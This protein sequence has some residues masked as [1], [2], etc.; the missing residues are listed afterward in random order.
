MN[1]TPLH[2]AMGLN[3]EDLVTLLLANDADTTVKDVVCRINMIRNVCSNLLTVL[4]WLKL[5]SY[6]CSNKLFLSHALVWD[7]LIFFLTQNH[8]L[9]NI[10]KMIIVILKIITIMILMAYG[11]IKSSL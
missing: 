1:R 9:F 7:F 6:I 3:N 8:K 5:I 4:N 2:Y 10:I 11:V